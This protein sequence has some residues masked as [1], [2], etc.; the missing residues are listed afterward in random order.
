MEFQIKFHQKFQKHT[1][2][3][4]AALTMQELPGARNCDLGSCEATRMNICSRSEGHEALRSIVLW[5]GLHTVVVQGVP[6]P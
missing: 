4:L 1:S 3:S 2:A 5:F 6:K